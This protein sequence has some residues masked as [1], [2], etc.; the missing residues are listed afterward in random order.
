MNQTDNSIY[1]NTETPIHTNT[2]TRRSSRR[3]QLHIRAYNPKKYSPSLKSNQNLWERGCYT[4]SNPCGIEWLNRSTCT[5]R[6]S[7][8]NV[9]S[10]PISVTRSLYTPCR[11]C[12][13]R[14]MRV[15]SLRNPGG[16]ASNRRPK[17][18]P[19]ISSTA[20]P[21]LDAHTTEAERGCDVMRAISPK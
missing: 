15:T 21:P 14:S 1:K 19:L 2:H 12:R 7:S 11:N 17:S 3:P 8:E 20:Q 13:A 4:P 9:A 16:L 6:T 18:S 10:L 5:N